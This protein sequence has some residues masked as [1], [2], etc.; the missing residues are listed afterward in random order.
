M[1]LLEPNID[2]TQE[3]TILDELIEKVATLRDR[4][5]ERKGIKETVEKEE[6]SNTIAVH[7]LRKK[8]I[9]KRPSVPNIYEKISIPSNK[10]LI[11]D[12][13]SGDLFLVE[14][15]EIVKPIPNI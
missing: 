1:K 12:I 2:K 4:L 7:K 14:K 15:E 5:R 13:Y 8:T 10:C 3:D 9:F 6:Q 11:V